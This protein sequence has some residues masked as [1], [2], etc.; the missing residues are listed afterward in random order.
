[1]NGSTMPTESPTLDSGT[2]RRLVDGPKLLEVLFEPGS[3]PSLRWLRKMQR[4][5]RL[6]FI[7]IG[8]LVR[9]DVEDVRRALDEKWTVRSKVRT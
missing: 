9:F 8:H 4:E 7:K 6:P 1:M 3:R 2:E 5:K